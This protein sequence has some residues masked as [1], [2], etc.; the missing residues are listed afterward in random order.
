[1]KR[2]AAIAL[3]FYAGSTLATPCDIPLPGKGRTLNDYLMQINR[4]DE[5]STTAQLHTALHDL[6]EYSPMGCG[7]AEPDDAYG[8]F[9]IRSARR[10]EKECRWLHLGVTP[11]GAAADRPPT[12]VLCE[13]SKNRV[14][15]WSCRFIAPDQKK[16]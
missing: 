10:D 7:D 13:P 4:G 1:M 8:K 12:Q 3:L 6:V 9:L 2:I 14:G 5:K 11:P 16:Y 15:G